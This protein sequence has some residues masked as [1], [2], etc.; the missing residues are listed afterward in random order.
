[1]TR[2]F[3]ILLFALIIF[4]ISCSVDSA[5]KTKS[6]KVF[7]IPLK[8]YSCDSDSLS[9]SNSA[10][11]AL[12][13]AG[14][15]RCMMPFGVLLSAGQDMP[16]AYLEMSGRILAE[17]LDQDIDGKM[18]D[19]SLSQYV[20]DWKTGWLAMPTD[21][22]QWENAQWPI[23]YSQL[24]YDIIIPSWWMGTSNAEPDEH[25]K[26]VMVE[27]ITHFLTQFG[28]GPRYP[29]KF[30]VEDWSSTIAQETAQAQCVWWQ[31]P[32]N[33]CPES[34]PTVQG[35]CSDSNC[36]VVE[37]YHQVLILRS[38]MEPG[39][40]GIGFPTTAAELDELLGDEMKSLMD[41]P[42]YHQLNSPL[43]FEYPLID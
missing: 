40:Y 20:S 5:D 22:E 16:I 21:K 42:N 7:D 43:T 17:M 6:E 9:I 4:N 35:D 29:E 30:G 24:G 34:P 15:T 31:H 33:S 25:A 18:D 36:D 11:N 19:L 2:P 8:V 1:L 41:D 3:K 13:S 38:G 28:Y 14:M 32:E 10:K 26:A 27:E 39:W 23:L 37:F 12:M